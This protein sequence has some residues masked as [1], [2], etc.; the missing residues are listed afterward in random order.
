MFVCAKCLITWHI[1]TWIISYWYV[2][3]TIFSKLRNIAP[4]INQLII[5][6]CDYYHDS[7]PLQ[8]TA[9]SISWNCIT[10]SNF[11]ISTLRFVELAV[12]LNITVWAADVGEEGWRIRA[13]RELLL[14]LCSSVTNGTG[15]YSLHRGPVWVYGEVVTSLLWV[16]HGEFERSSVVIS[17]FRHSA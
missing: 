6:C 3:P 10:Y 7:L 14:Q 15:W 12:L 1:F 5:N 8:N 17:S 4:Q 2:G 9:S 11:L 13:G 16:L